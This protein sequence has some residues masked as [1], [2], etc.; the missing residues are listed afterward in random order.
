LQN[1][2]SVGDVTVSASASIGAVYS[3]KPHELRFEQLIQLADEALYEAKAAGRN[4]H[5]LREF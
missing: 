2:Y 3:S 4:C 1:D 5:F